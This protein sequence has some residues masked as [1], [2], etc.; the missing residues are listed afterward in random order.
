MKTEI[1]CALIAAAGAI[2]SA[3]IAWFVSRSTANKE[4]EQLKLT[5][6]RE[7]IVSSDDEFAKMASVVANYIKCDIPGLQRE[8]LSSVA[9][10]RSK[11]SGELGSLLDQLYSVID[12]GDISLVDQVLTSVINKKREAKSKAKSP[13]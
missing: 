12:Y 6:E 8:A 9:A 7:D 2:L 4:I 3:L 13:K 1:L 10:I 11:E 5:W